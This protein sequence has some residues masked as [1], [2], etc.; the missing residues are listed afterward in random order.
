MS[1]FIVDFGSCDM[2]ENP[3]DSSYLCLAVSGAWA[4]FGQL[5][6]TCEHIRELL[7]AE[8]KERVSSLD[9]MR[10]REGQT[11][12]AITEETKDRLAGD[13]EQASRLRELAAKLDTERSE[14]VHWLHDS[15]IT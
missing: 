15:Q 4:R 5:M 11:R 2:S 8:Q 3:V 9:E 12:R 7:S 1:I 13:A 6:S 10:V 14:R